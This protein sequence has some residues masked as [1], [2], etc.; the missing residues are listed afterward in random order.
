MNV[1]DQQ[2]PG[3]IDQLEALRTSI[4]QDEALR[5]Q[6][7]VA[8]Q[9]LSLAIETPLDTVRRIAFSVIIPFSKAEL[10]T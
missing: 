4:P 10:V 6:L 5:Y 9:K 2:V 7:S 8:L 1:S 3:L